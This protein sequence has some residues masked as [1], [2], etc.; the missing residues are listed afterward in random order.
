MGTASSGY[1]SISESTRVLGE[2]GVSSEPDDARRGCSWFC[3]PCSSSDSSDCPALFRVSSWNGF[4]A[5]PVGRG[6]R[7]EDWSRSSHAITF[8]LCWSEV[9]V[10]L[11]YASIERGVARYGL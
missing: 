10:A 5:E 9:D 3:D 7:T 8:C 2:T 4:E 1:G 11:R 6:E